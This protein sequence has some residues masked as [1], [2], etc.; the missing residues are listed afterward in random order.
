MIKFGTDG[1]RA[2]IS[3]D[4][5]FENVVLVSQAIAD[6]FN[7]RAQ[8]SQR[9]DAPE[10]VVGYDTRFLSESYAQMVAEVLSGNGIKVYLINKPSPTPMVCFFIKKHKL[11]GGIIITASHNPPQYNGIKIKMDYAGP[12]EPEVTKEIESFI[13][14]SKIRRINQKEAIEKKLLELID[15]SQEYVKFLRSY[16][17]LSL[18]RRRSYRILVDVMYG[19]GDDFIP[20]ILKGTKCKVTLL[21]QERN[22]LF[23]GI[24]PEPIP[25]NMKEVVEKMKK[26]KFDLAIVNDGDA[27]RVSCVRPDGRIIN[28]G[29]VLALIILHL[30]EDRKWLGGVVKT[31]SNTTLINK[32]AQKYNLKLY[33]TAVGFK[34]VAKIMREEDILA[35]GEESGGI[36]VK[37]YLP[38]RDGM[39][40]GLLILEMM[41][42]RRKSIIEIMN[43][44]DR[45]FG[46]FYY[47]REDI[48]YPQ[49]LKN[50]LFL[51]LKEK[52]FENI[53]G[54]KVLEVK[55]FDGIKFISADES[56]LLFRLSGTE[57][58][59]RIYAE[60][61]TQKRA[62]M[63]LKFGK[64][65]ALNL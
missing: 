59:L 16:L 37:H 35:G 4:F 2:V 41:A 56:W 34:Y 63:L 25:K 3:D 18:L 42:Y 17:N 21:H 51:V 58:I 31:I 65:F 45:E 10:I 26:G 8:L 36:G 48:H 12:A 53:L 61:H 19:T 60:A 55:D 28:A 39:L 29:G 9:K 33:E 27:D 47:V 5:T 64:E 11:S 30:L 54:K 43:D 1:W 44:I 20:R 46:K 38:E 52:P 15:P 24:N 49:E 40:T 7:K 6:Y 62:D 57:P 14:Q 13:G 32:I 50:K 22:P 23:G